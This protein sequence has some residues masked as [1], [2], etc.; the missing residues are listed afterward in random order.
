MTNDLAAIFL[1]LGVIH[2]YWAG[3]GIRWF[4]EAIPVREDGN[5]LFVPGVVACIIIGLGL[6]L[7]SLLYVIKS[8]LVNVDLP[9]WT[10]QG[11]GWLVAS[12][13]TIR[14]IGDFK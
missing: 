13:F 10:L 11:G 9:S 7:F 6:T 14:G 3:G 8:G 4:E 5:P 1:T 2:F 12:I